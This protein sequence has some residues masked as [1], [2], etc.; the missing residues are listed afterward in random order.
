MTIRKN[1]L[2]GT[3]AAVL[4]SS[5]QAL[6]VDIPPPPP[7]EPVAESCFYA[8]IDGGYSFHQTP[9]IYKNGAAP[10]AGGSQA[11]DEEL[12]DTWFIE[13]GVG[14]YV[15]ES[16]RIDATLGYRHDADMEEAFGG[17]DADL[18]TVFGFVNGYYDIFTWGRVTPYVGGGVGF[19]HHDIDNVNLPAGISGGSNTDFAW[20]L[21]AGVAVDITYNLALD[22]GYRY[23]DFGRAETG[24]TPG[25]FVDDITSHDIRIGLRY[26]FRDW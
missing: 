4:L 11:T 5:G 20:N 25:M 8:R 6:A 19:A 12:D 7:P 9:D 22:V 18:S 17:L 24:G 15:F 23:A 21:Q 14:C 10:W 26:S 1:T 2:L 13:G 3:V 16:F